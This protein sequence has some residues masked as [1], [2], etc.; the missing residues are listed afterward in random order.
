VNVE[1]DLA[2]DEEFL[3]YLEADSRPIGL[4][5]RCEPDATPG[6]VRER[7]R[8]AGAYLERLRTGTLSERG[9]EK[10]ARV[11]YRIRARD[12]GIRLMLFEH[13][14]AVVR[15]RCSPWIVFKERRWDEHN[16][17][18]FKGIMWDATVREPAFDEEGILPIRLPRMV[19]RD[20]EVTLTKVS[21]PHE[22]ERLWREYQIDD[23]FRARAKV[24]SERI[25][26]H[27]LK[28]LPE[29]AKPTKLYCTEA[30]RS[31]AKMQRFRQNSPDKH[32]AIQERYWTDDD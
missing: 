14:R 16:E 12:E 10:L 26:Q 6:T 21:T 29:G 2:R 9:L 24:R 15:A 17:F 13:D 11:A 23:Y 19:L 32:L 3:R 8:L 27:C 5:P 31:A 7:M 22:Y 30:C 20:D 1:E 4:P 28:P 25:C 18:T